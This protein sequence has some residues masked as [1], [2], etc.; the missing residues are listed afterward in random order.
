MVLRLHTTTSSSADASCCRIDCSA[1]TCEPIAISRIR[2]AAVARPCAR[3]SIGWS[4]SAASSR[5]TRPVGSGSQSALPRQRWS[6]ASDGR[7]QASSDE[8]GRA[9]DL[10]LPLISPWLVRT[11]LPPWPGGTMRLLGGGEWDHSAAFEA[12]LNRAYPICAF[13]GSR[14]LVRRPRAGRAGQAGAPPPGLL[15]LSR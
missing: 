15:L 3:A 12:G 11:L 10:R 2:A 9:A 14:L 5:G 6:G 13:L 4:T 1:S 8:R 7:G